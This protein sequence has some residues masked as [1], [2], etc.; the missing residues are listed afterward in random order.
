M[1]TER[2]TINKRD[3]LRSPQRTTGS[4]PVLPPRTQIGDKWSP[5][6]NPCRTSAER[7]N[8]GN[9]RT[10]VRKARRAAQ[11]NA[12]ALELEAD[13]NLELAAKTPQWTGPRL[14][15]LITSDINYPLSHRLDQLMLMHSALSAVVIQYEF[16]VGIVRPVSPDRVR[17]SDFTRI[18][19]LRCPSSC[20]LLLFV[21][22]DCTF[23][24]LSILTQQRFLFCWRLGLVA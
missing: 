21:A 3:E 22:A 17:E 5:L 20:S 10:Q 4:Q 9:P 2:S 19:D 24:S 12:I 7:I 1:V 11:L 15:S 13:I 16:G 23:W 18:L 6:N 14:H 8:N